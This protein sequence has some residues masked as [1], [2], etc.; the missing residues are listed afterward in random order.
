[1]TCQHNNRKKRKCWVFH[2]QTK[3]ITSE[4]G[5]RKNPSLSLSFFGGSNVSL[6]PLLFFAPVF[7]SCLRFLP[8]PQICQSGAS[9]NA[10]SCHGIFC[11]CAHLLN[12]W[13]LLKRYLFSPPPSYPFYIPVGFWLCCFKLCSFFIFFF[14]FNVKVLIW[15][16]VCFVCVCA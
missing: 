7:S 11:Y 14:S 9:V 2:F 3:H 12:I 8:S 15:F 4:Y 1:M 13:F 10:H 16:W 5:K 6:K